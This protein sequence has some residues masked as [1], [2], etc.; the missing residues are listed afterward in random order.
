MIEEN[1]RSAKRK[2]NMSHCIYYAYWGDHNVNPHPH[3]HDQ[4]E[5][6]I[7]PEQYW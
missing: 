3:L 2:I 6:Y 7:S 1:T 4:L 5:I